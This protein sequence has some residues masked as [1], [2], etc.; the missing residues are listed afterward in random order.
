VRFPCEKTC[1]VVE[2]A[3]NDA[4]HLLAFHAGNPALRSDWYALELCGMLGFHPYAIEL[5]GRLIQT[6]NMP[7]KVLIE[8]IQVRPLELSQGNRSVR[9]LLEGCVGGLPGAART[10]FRSFGRL[11]AAGATADLLAVYI[12]QPTATV[13]AGLEI[14]LERSLVR[15]PAS[16][17]DYYTMHDLVFHYARVV[18]QE[19][20]EP[21]SPGAI[22]PLLAYL[23]EHAHTAATIH[24]DI[25]N[26]LGLAE[27]ASDADLLRIMSCLTI[28][29]FPDAAPPSYFDIYGHS[30]PYLRLLDRVLAASGSNAVPPA[31]TRHYLYGKRAD[32]YSDYGLWDEA[33][34]A[35]QTALECAPNVQRTA[36]ILCCL[37]GVRAEQRQLDEAE[38][39]LD[40]ADALAIECRA[41]VTRAV[42]LLQRSLLAGEGRQNP[43][44][45][46]E[47]CV[48][49]IEI[50]RQQP[51]PTADLARALLN[52][53]TAN[54]ELG[55]IDAGMAA[56]REAEDLFVAWG[57]Q[58]GLGQV[59]FLMG[60][61][62]LINGSNGEARQALRKAEEACRT[63]GALSKLREVQERLRS[64][65]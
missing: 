43:A 42:V 58:L 14:L 21:V 33:A 3:G 34:A 64:I 61:A 4:A 32:A 49:A 23:E 6:L 31:A 44:A 41:P 9:S 13:R 2:L 11:A 39:L 50:L 45:A 51:R 47:Y 35:L 28:G 40:R 38:Q 60:G 65:A 46:R 63:A 55:D 52:L 24:L 57:D 62:H 37:A 16:T 54:I 26:I 27:N 7:A 17:L 1:E 5:A 20:P 8:R 53:G 56:Y 29:G 18:G 22:Q 19:S 59:Y 25:T 10:V 12:G 15:K 48:Q 36:H 30:A